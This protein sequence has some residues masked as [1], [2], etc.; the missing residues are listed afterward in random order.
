MFTVEDYE[1]EKIIGK[2]S[3]GK[4]YRVQKK[5]NKHT[6]AIKIL[7][8]PLAAQI[9]KQLIINEIR[10]LASHNCK[11]IIDYSTVFIKHS[12][13]YIVMEYA[14]K[15]DLHQYIKYYKSNNKKFSDS[16]LFNYFI[17]IAQGIKYLHKHNIIHRDIK[18]ANI[19]IDHNN[20]LKLG[21]FG[22]IKI[23]QNHSMQA[24]T[25][26][27]TPCYM[28][29]ELYRY[30]RYNTKFD[31]WSLGCVLYE[32][33][34][35]NPPFNGRSLVD[36]KYKIFSGKYNNQILRPYASELRYIVSLTLNTN[37][38]LRPSIEQVLKLPALLSKLS[39][40]KLS[41]TSDYNINPLF[42]EQ[43][44]IPRK[45]SD[46][47]AIIKKYSKPIISSTK[48]SSLPSITKTPISKPI[49]KPI[50]PVPHPPN[51]PKPQLYRPKP[52]LP[53]LQKPE[54]LHK[55]KSKPSKPPLPQNNKSKE[56]III[57]T[58]Q[59]PIL[60]NADNK[61]IMDIDLDI[62]K[63]SQSIKE[64]RAQLDIKLFRLEHLKKKR[65]T[66][67][68]NNHQAIVAGN[69]HITPHPPLVPISQFKKNTD[70]IPNCE[71]KLSLH[72]ASPLSYMSPKSRLIIKIGS[73]HDSNY[74][75]NH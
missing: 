75:L 33:M 28:P 23:L 29:P 24:N 18:T 5:S 35:F 61:E 66:I 41:I 53:I 57:H 4:V 52:A 58:E 10:L 60:S 26:I 34:A 38:T 13:I 7:N 25:Q 15:G 31:I 56:N 40:L 44:N 49:S 73:K 8:L 71:D 74:F 36:L 59:I 21:D 68:D 37:P 50:Y 70:I 54:P 46:W 27:G 20:N 43:Y 65:K 16:E 17:Q 72:K 67:I 9:D 42:F 69:N 14:K 39:I 2:G 6:Y 12:S 55:S 63:V 45:Q 3:F 1:F 62:D 48:L 51:K 22:I 30:Q 64:L 11:H 32:M 47:V 19:F